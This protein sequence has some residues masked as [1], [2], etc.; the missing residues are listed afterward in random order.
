MLSLFPSLFVAEFCVGVVRGGEGKVGCCGRWES[1]WESGSCDWTRE[2]VNGRALRAMRSS[3]FS[4]A[5]AIF[6]VRI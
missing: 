4:V 1:M 3:F 2:R 5:F 6:H